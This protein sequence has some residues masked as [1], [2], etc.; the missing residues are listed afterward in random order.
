MKKDEKQERQENLGTQDRWNII[1]RVK[2]RRNKIKKKARTKTY[3]W[4]YLCIYIFQD[5][6]DSRWWVDCWLFPL[7][8]TDVSRGGRGIFESVT[9]SSA[10]PGRWQYIALAK[11]VLRTVSATTSIAIDRRCH[12]VLSTLFYCHLLSLSRQ[13]VKQRKIPQLPVQPTRAPILISEQY[14]WPTPNSGKPDRTTYHW[15][16]PVCFT[17]S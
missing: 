5:S 3:I 7:I 4:I 11:R 16:T 1:T 9:V 14:R 17:P 10:H 6:R 13:G 8:T 15:A 12:T 2:K